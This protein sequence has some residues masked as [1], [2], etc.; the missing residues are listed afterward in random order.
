MNT[1]IIHHGFSVVRVIVV[2]AVNEEAIAETDTMGETGDV[3][4][5]ATVTKTF[6]L[7]PGTYVMFCNIDNKNGGTVLNH[8]TQGMVTT[9]IAV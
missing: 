9:L 7:P 1:S 6:E 8:F 3:A 2:G 4:V 5:G